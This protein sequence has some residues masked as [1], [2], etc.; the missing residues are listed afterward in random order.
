MRICSGLSA[1]EVEAPGVLSP[2]SLTR[3]THPLLSLPLSSKSTLP[4]PTQLRTCSRRSSV[5]HPRSSSKV[6]EVTVADLPN[7]SNSFS[8]RL[9]SQP[10]R[11]RPLSFRCS[12]SQLPSQ[13]SRSQTIPFYTKISGASTIHCS[14]P[15]TVKSRSRA[16]FRPGCYRRTS[17]KLTNP[18]SYPRNCS[19]H[20]DSG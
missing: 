12:N 10:C 6:M 19:R 16:R 17:S 2:Q 7:R 1:A 13:V 3:P 5:S 9:M 18:R 14:T 15:V 4:M 20:L 11:P 8:F